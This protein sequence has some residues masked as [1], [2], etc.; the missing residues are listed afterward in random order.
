VG[1]TSK[2]HFQEKVEGMSLRKTMWLAAAIFL[3]SLRGGAW[4]SSSAHI[5]GAVSVTVD[6]DKVQNFVAARAMGMHTS[7]YDNHLGGRQ[8]AEILRS[9]GI[10]TLRYPGGGYSD[11]YH[12]S[13]HKMTKWK[14]TDPRNTDI[15]API[16]ISDIFFNWWKRF[17]AQQSLR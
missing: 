14:G 12:W 2:T 4:Q 6:A 15:L 9:A 16:L 1:K 8:L 13:V 7:V 5:E 11:N 3:F 17:R 10:T